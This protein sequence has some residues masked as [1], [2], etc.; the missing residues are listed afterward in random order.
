MKLKLIEPL[1]ILFKDEVRI[2]GKTLGLPEHM[3][4]RQ[5]FPG[6]GIAV[7]IVGDITRDK[8]KL[9]QN[10]DAILQEEIAEAGLNKAI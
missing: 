9:V 4:N 8:I 10:S 2:L 6:P 3:V 5:P 1:N 7:R